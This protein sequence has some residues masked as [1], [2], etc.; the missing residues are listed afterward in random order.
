[1]SPFIDVLATYDDDIQPDTETTEGA[2]KS[3]RNDVLQTMRKAGVNAAF[4]YVPLH[5]S[6]AGRKFAVRP[7]ECPVTEDIA[8]RLLRLPF[9]NNLAEHDLDRTVDTFLDA[10]RSTQ[11]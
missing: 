9:Y 8:G 11:V 7:T 1:M 3:R 4:H 2:A 6:E 10:V 5:T